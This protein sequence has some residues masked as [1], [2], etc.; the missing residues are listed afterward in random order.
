MEIDEEK[1]KYYIERGYLDS[2]DHAKFKYIVEILRLFNIKVDG[3]MKGSYIL[4]ENE[5]IM[6]TKV[7][8]ENWTDTIDEQYMYELCNPQENK[9]IA[10]RNDFWGDKT[11]Y[12]FRK[13]LNDDYE[14]IGCF[15]QDENKIDELFGK[16]VINQRP[17]KKIDSRVDLTRFNKKLEI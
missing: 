15:K 4:N 16:G 13:E 8:N 14:F 1:I 2:D 11:I 10:R 12:I 3:W 7:K 17:Y 5:G 6:F 9:Q